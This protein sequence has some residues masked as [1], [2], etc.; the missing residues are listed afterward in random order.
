MATGQPT[1]IPEEPLTGPGGEVGD[2]HV[3]L[4]GKDERKEQS[5]AIATRVRPELQAIGK[6]FGANVKVIEVPPEEY[7]DL[8]CNAVTLA[9]G[10]VVLNAGSP[11]PTIG[12]SGA[13]A[14]VMGAYLIKFPHA[15]IVTLV[16]VFDPGCGS[17][18]HSS[19]CP[20]SNM[21][22]SAS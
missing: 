9:P 13:I 18:V 3:N 12:A 16:P 10:K 14:G 15:R 1:L 5:H 6:R 4:V 22:S 20:V 17:C 2:L 19:G 7:W 8:A 21:K 11:V